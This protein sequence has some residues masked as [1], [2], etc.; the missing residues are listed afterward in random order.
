MNS[1][2]S[3]LYMKIANDLRMQIHTGK[4]KPSDKLPTEYELMQL[5]DVSRITASKAVSILA[6]EGLIYRARKL[7]TFVKDFDK[8]DSFI[9]PMESLNPN[10]KRMFPLVFPFSMNNGLN[11]IDGILKSESTN[12]YYFVPYNSDNRLE[13]ER[14]ILTN[15]LSMNPPGVI[16]HPIV[17]KKNI[18]LFMQF[19]AK[20]IPL[21]FIDHGIYGIDAPCVTTDNH[22]ISYNLTNKLIAMGHTRIA[23]ICTN[24]T[25]DTVKAR[26][27]GILKAL[28]D[29]NM[30]MPE[31]FFIE[32]KGKNPSHDILL[33]DNPEDFD[34]PQILKSLLSLE[35][36]PTV[37]VCANDAIAIH[38]EKIALSMGLSIPK[39]ISITSFD[40]TEL[41]KHVSVPLTSVAQNYE[42]L[43]S[44]AISIFNRLTVKSP[45]P[46]LTRVPATIVWRDSVR[47]FTNINVDG[48]F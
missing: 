42:Q 25:L 17:S 11:I 45:V 13:N 24:S 7:G 1:S 35:N 4:I 29:H 46:S 8:D 37:L 5:Y 23:F 22:A 39:D 31:E 28:I 26:F 10:Q 21:I 27:S 3:P 43:G 40:N 18:P 6:E 12:Q 9:S 16:C 19:K 32:I 47:N 20:K 44:E 30:I 2:F 38:I 15:L 41:C 33:S 36:S 14:E 48:Y 34:L